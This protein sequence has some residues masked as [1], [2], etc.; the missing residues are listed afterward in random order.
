MMRRS[1]GLLVLAMGAALVAGVVGLLAPAAQAARIDRP[2]KAEL[3]EALS[4]SP[5]ILWLGS[6]TSRE[7]D[8][9]QVAALTG[10]SVFNA[11]VSAGQPFEARFFVTTVDRRFPTE[12][13]HLVIALDV[14]QLR[15]EHASP[16]RRRP[17]GAKPL[18]SK[19][20]RA[21][22]FRKINPYVG[23]RLARYLGPSIERYRREVYPRLRRLDPTQLSHLR[24]ILA[25]ANERG[26]TPTIVLMPTQPRFAAAMRRYGRAERRR[27]L[28]TW[29]RRTAAEGFRFRVADESH[30]RQFDGTAAGFYDGVHMRPSNMAR[31][32]RDLHVRGMLE[33]PASTSLTRRARS[34][35]ARGMDQVGPRG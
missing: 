13:P 1:V 31:M 10:R 28:D 27:E 3:M 33:P 34:A 32:I 20:Y 14:E 15:R 25:L 4:A 22:G 23:R 9:R 16:I 12:L 11:A 8:P 35:Q 26:G 2:M 24:A 6:S 5:K 18:P 17:A 29:I 19:R 30:I 7:A 21:D